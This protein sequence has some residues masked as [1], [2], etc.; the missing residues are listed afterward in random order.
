MLLSNP[1]RPDPRVLKEAESLIEAGFKVSIICWDRQ[2][3]FPPEEM[4]ISGIHIIRVQNVPST[5]GAGARQLTRLPAFWREVIRRL[6]TLRPAL[7]H[8]HDFD[9]LPA[10]LWYGWRK[11]IP[12]IY[13]AHEYYAELIRPRLQGRS[14][15]FIVDAIRRLDLWSAGRAS[16][17]V[18]VDETL[19]AIYRMRNRRVVIVG[20]YPSR[21]L[22][23]E[24]AEV[25]TRPQ[26]NLLYVGRLSADR[27]T[28]IYARLLWHLLDR[29]IP[30]RLHLAGSFI[31][32][33]ER[34]TFIQQIG[35][36]EDNI[37][38]HG[39]VAYDQLPELLRIADIGLAILL[40]EPR[41]I[42]A[43]PVKLFEYM[44]AGLPVVAS[45][46][47]QVREVVES[48]TCGLLV[49]PE[50]ELKQVADA[51]AEWWH[52][53]EIP[54]HLGAN[55][56]RAIQDQYNW[57]NLAARLVGLYSELIHDT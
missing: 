3:E 16:A 4:T 49:D 26:M 50:Q 11:R 57:E 53:P 14:G 5:Y 52:H 10:G 55:G 48:S 17:V 15:Y 31:P 24:P 13:D 34:E 33:G 27:G 7:I 44:A 2:S 56:R 35:G 42:A 37:K 51:I 45:N 19:G 21:N 23:Q 9:T 29:G 30:V 20:H 46:F 6:N 32:E 41:Y 12:V 47:P 1:F 40:P 25:F 38:D 18:T 28:L 54:R 36:L 39:W 22:V 43:L 8:C